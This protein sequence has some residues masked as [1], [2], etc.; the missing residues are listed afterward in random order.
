MRIWS[1]VH[2]FG[3]ICKCHMMFNVLNGVYEKATS[4]YHMMLDVHNGIYFTCNYFGYQTYGKSWKTT[5]GWSDMDF[6]ITCWSISFIHSCIDKISS[7]KNVADYVNSNYVADYVHWSYSSQRKLIFSLTSLLQSEP[8]LALH[9]LTS[10]LKW[11]HLFWWTYISY[12]SRKNSSL[13][14]MAK[15]Q[16]RHYSIAMV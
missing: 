4:G 8:Y 15:S 7:S 11:W 16:E 3:V 1:G 12:L 6:Q 9:K 5:F 10:Y 14:Q 2:G 13:H